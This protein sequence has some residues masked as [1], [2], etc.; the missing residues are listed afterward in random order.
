M[1]WMR[2]FWGDQH[3]AVVTTELV[4]ITSVGVLGLLSGL[5]SVRGTVV[6]EMS[7]MATTVQA[8]SRSYFDDARAL[9]HDGNRS[10][11]G[12][13]D[14]FADAATNCVAIDN[15]FDDHSS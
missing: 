10:E 9:T 3:G 5:Q 6:D 13:S 2:Y 8:V 4:L 14:D 15:P 11:P 12:P 1:N 7:N